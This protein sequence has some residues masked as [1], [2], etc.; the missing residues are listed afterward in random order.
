MN[1]ID[2][3]AETMAKTLDIYVQWAKKNGLPENEYFVLYSVYHNEQ[4]S[5]KTICEEW[6]LPKQTISFVC[7]QLIE[8]GWLATEANP[9]DK[10]GKLLRLTEQGKAKIEPI[11]AEQTALESQSAVEFGEEKLALL[12]KEL[13]ALHRVLNR[14]LGA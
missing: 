6:C 1:N 9:N 11:I 5:Q 3:L 13:Q 7:K 14:N 10:R 8:R 12:V 4:C 2:L